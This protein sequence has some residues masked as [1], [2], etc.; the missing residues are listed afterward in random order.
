MTTNALA[1][2]RDLLELEIR[3]YQESSPPA[4]YQM[5][6][7]LCGI[8]PR[9]E[10]ITEELTGLLHMLDMMIAQEETEKINAR[11]KTPSPLYTHGGST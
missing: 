6:C 5:L 7:K 4:R 9:H 11:A 2:F 8:R 1:R 3:F 10:V